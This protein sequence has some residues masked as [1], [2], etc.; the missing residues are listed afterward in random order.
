MDVFLVIVR[1]FNPSI[2]V[3]VDFLQQKDHSNPFVAVRSSCLEELFIFLT[4]SKEAVSE[5]WY[6]EIPN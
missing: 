6:V 2:P 1:T 3:I 5:S 4:E